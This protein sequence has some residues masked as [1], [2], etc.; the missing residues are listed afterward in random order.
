MTPS[1]RWEKYENPLIPK[2]DDNDD[3]V[4]E[5]G[6]DDD[7]EPEPKIHK[8]NLGNF[9]NTPYGLVPVPNVHLDDNWNMW[10]GHTNVP[11]T[12]DIATKIENTP[13]VEILDIFSAYRFRISVAMHPDFRPGYVMAEIAKNAFGTPIPREEEMEKEIANRIDKHR[14]RIIKSGDP[15]WFIFVFPNGKVVSKNSPEENEKYLSSLSIVNDLKG[16]VNG[17][18]ITNKD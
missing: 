6:F 15:H 12:K 9:I 10:V 18:L 8:Q 4:E 3:F 7:Y 17:V 16:K 2:D 14:Q 5:K 11:I 1:I 13:G